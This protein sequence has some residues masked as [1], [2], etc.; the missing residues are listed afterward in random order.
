MAKTKS[1]P[2]SL[3]FN[4]PGE[5]FEIFFQIIKRMAWLAS[6]ER[7]LFWEGELNTTS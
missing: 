5:I 6:M 4:K 2:I 1:E 7:L 3:F